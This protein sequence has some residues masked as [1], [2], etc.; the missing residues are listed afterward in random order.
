ML[1]FFYLHAQDSGN[2]QDQK[3]KRFQVGLSYVYMD[4]DMKV[5]NMSISSVWQDVDFGTSEL[6]DDEIDELNSLVDR[7]TK[8]NGLMLEAGATLCDKPGSKWLIDG[9]LMLGIGKSYSNTYN[10]STDTNEMELNSKFTDPSFGIR[11][12]ILHQFNPKWGLLIR[13][14]AV[15]S[16]GASDDIEDNMYPYVD[17]FTET[18]ED[19]FITAY[20]RINIMATY[21]A[22]KFKI[23]LGPGFYYALSH[24]NYKVERINNSNGDILRDEISSNL[25]PRSFI[26]GVA[27][28]E[29]AFF[30]PFSLN[31]Y[32]G[33][34]K[35]ISARGGL[36]YKF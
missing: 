28:I 27:A 33:V 32:V 18:R 24:H 4:L 21:T 12:N 19:K 35:D 10:H 31:V 7:T 30:D 36:Y 29:W 20:E 23:S 15:I 2:N 8:L 6:T 3:E 9:S 22:G 17:N 13:P 14:I 16:F 11:F 26:D 1:M 25:V 5:R 34:G